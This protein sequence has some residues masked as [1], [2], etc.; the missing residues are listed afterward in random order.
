MINIQIFDSMR[1]I[2]LKQGDWDRLVQE[3]ENVGVFSRYFWITNWWR[4]F[5]KA[6]EL[7]FLTADD[8]GRIIAFAP[9]MIDENREL[10]FI[11]DTNADYL[12]FVI[13][14]D[15]ELVMQRFLETLADIRAKWRVMHLRNI[16]CRQAGGKALIAQARNAGLYPWMNYAEVAP[17]L[18]IADNDEIVGSTVG[19]YSVRRSNRL[20][21]QQGTVRFRNFETA[22]EADEYWLSFRQQNMERCNQ[23]G[24]KSSFSNPDYLPFLRSLFESDTGR[25]H[26]L[27]S[28]VFMD[29]RPIAFHFGYISQGRLLWYKPSF[30]ISV[31]K[32]SPGISLIC[33][34][35]QYAQERGLSELDFT[36]GDEAF[37]DRFCSGKRTVES[38][39]IHRSFSRY[40]ADAGHWWFR[41]KIK[42]A[43][44]LGGK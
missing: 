28:A 36:I 26:V 22:E 33:H 39:R 11:G 16:P 35:I 18:K 6:Y 17:Y 27:F 1:D 32:G 12:D 5:G 14:R 13:S 23:V 4:F 34:L 3:S 9:L 29:D 21:A 2:P 30:D 31:E 20:L 40:A 41:T 10:C 7:C 15:R 8:N 25:E 38:F 42:A 24:R 19:K 44:G 37:K 43:L